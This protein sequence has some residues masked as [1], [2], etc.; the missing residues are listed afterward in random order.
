VTVLKGGRSFNGTK[1]TVEGDFFGANAQ[2]PAQLQYNKRHYL[3]IRNTE[4]GETRQL[5]TYTP[6]GTGEQTVT[7]SPTGNVT[8]EGPQAIYDFKPQVG[9]IPARQ[10]VPFDVRV[11]SIDGMTFSTWNVSIYHINQTANTSTPIYT[12]ES[13]SDGGVVAPSLDLS[14][15]S[16][17]TLR[18]VVTWEAEDGTTGRQV[19]EK[20]VVAAPESEFSLLQ[21][22]ASLVN[23]VPSDN[24]DVFTGTL[25]IVLVI[26]LTAGVAS[27]VPMTSEM[28]GAIALMWLTGF[29]VIGWLSYNIV[30]V[31]LV[32]WASIAF[33]RRRY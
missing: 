11:Q 7:V 15:R 5:G 28:I 19:Y 10:G 1:Q 22:L 27:T 13:S 9:Q 25:A 2:F 14:N 21:A 32:A 16:N 6:L 23:L 4:T 29:A 8:I 31:G 17:G 33:L 20:Q 24:Q 12:N 18:A 26:L 3:V 30:F